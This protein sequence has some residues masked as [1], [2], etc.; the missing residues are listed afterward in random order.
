MEILTHVHAVVTRLSFPSQESLGT[1]LL[2]TLTY[3]YLH[4]A[5]ECVTTPSLSVKWGQSALHMH[6][7]AIELKSYLQLRA[8]GLLE[9]YLGI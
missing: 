6:T 5:I 1:R 2:H 3:M 9:E 4:G 8:G 7:T